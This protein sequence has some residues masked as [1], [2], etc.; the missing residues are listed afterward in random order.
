MKKQRT[1]K[2]QYNNWLILLVALSWGIAGYVS[3]NS[4]TNLV[5]SRITQR[6]V[7]CSSTAPFIQCMEQYSEPVGLEK[8][9]VF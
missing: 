1:Y 5:N 4:L 8:L 7:D 2:A 6:I 9:V 3:H